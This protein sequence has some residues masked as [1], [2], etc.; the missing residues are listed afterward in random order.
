MPARYTP[1][2]PDSLQ[3]CHTAF[4]AALARATYGMAIN[5]YESMV[6]AD[7]LEAFAEDNVLDRE[8]FVERHAAVMRRKFNRSLGVQPDRRDWDSAG[9]A[10]HWCRRLDLVTEATGDDGVRRWTLVRKSSPGGAIR[11]SAGPRSRSRACRPQSRPPTTSRSS[12]P[13]RRLRSGTQRPA[14]RPRP[15][16]RKTSIG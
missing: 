14:P 5:K 7:L 10:L 4:E 15:E 13:P 1:R 11:R 16:S 6:N 2:Q 8:T 9:N 12:V 3:L